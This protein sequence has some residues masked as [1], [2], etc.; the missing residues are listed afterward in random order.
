MGGKVLIFVIILIVA[1]GVG[2]YLY[3]SK[4]LVS[5]I[6]DFSAFVSPHAGSSTASTSGSSASATPSFWSFL[7][8]SGFSPQIVGPSIPPGEPQTYLSAPPSDS[9]GAN[10]INPADI[11]AGYTAA[12]LS[13]YFHEVRI[14]S[15]SAATFYNYGTI[16]LQD[17]SYNSTGTIDVTGWMIKSNIGNEFV[18][19]AVDLYDPTGL[20][21]ATDILMKDGDTVYL[22]SSSAPFNLR[23]NECTGYMAHVAN[24]V[25]AV[26]NT[27]PYIDQSQIQSFTGQCQQFIQSI[28]QCQTPDMSSPQVPQNDYACMQYLENNFTYR[29][30]FNAHSADANFLSNQVWVWT[31]ANIVDQY[32]NTILLLD[33]NG[34]LVDLYNY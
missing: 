13:P 26:P 32:H 14:G 18:P 29:S 20:A 8:V 31:G 22:Y 10:P 24:F 19:Q 1:L 3:N 6:G 2:L 17:E 27:C 4:V 16:T 15:I 33:K 23:L 25:P 12:Q 34:L 5:G 7:G 9:S 21:P 30:C 11:P 28:G